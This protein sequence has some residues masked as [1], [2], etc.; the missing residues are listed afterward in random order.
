MFGFYYRKCH[1]VKV[2]SSKLAPEFFLGR[3]LPLF[4][5]NALISTLGQR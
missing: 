1:E 2:L 5:E 4:W 3:E